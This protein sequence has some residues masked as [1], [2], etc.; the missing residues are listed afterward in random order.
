MST[1]RLASMDWGDWLYSLIHAVIGGGSTAVCGGL[2]A[3]IIKPSDF[4]LGGMASIKLMGTMFFI[5]AAL[6]LFLFLKDS[7]LPA[8]M[9]ISSQTVT[10]TTSESVPPKEEVKP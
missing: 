8:K 6:S 3:S 1:S 10:V 9:N 5:N 7:P 4:A 2:S